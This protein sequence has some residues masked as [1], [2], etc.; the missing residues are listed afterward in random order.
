MSLDD[1]EKPKPKVES[2]AARLRAEGAK[3]FVPGGMPK[4]FEGVKSAVREKKP[5]GQR[6]YGEYKEPK[7]KHYLKPHQYGPYENEMEVTRAI[8]AGHHK[9]ENT[10]ALY[11]AAKMREKAQKE[12]N[13]KLFPFYAKPGPK[14]PERKAKWIPGFAQRPEPEEE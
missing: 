8:A 4:R 13:R 7:E 3:P 10:A 9:G 14:P 11:H 5:L 2:S 12:E 6:Q 1:E